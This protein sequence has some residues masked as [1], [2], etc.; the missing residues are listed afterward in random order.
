MLCLVSKK[1]EHED[2]EAE[3]LKQTPAD[4]KQEQELEHAAA[5][6]KS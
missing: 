3:K 6:E 4:K 2:S 1:G 5:V